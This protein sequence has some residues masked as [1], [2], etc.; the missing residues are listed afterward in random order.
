MVLEKGTLPHQKIS[1]LK[2]MMFLHR[3]I[4]KYTWTY[5]VV[6]TQN[7]VDHILIDR[8]WHSSILDVRSVRIADCDIGN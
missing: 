8:K 2:S 3:N 1:F 6:K 4:R 5:P 7:Q